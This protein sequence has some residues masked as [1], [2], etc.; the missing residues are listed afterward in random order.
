MDCSAR[1]R[2]LLRVSELSDVV[3]YSNLKTTGIYPFLRQ[4]NVHHQ[5]GGM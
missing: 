3:N 5:A 4:D 2:N 1:G